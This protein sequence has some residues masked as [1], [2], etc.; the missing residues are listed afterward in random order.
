MGYIQKAFALAQEL[1]TDP[2]VI[3]RPMAETPEA[4]T[5]VFEKHIVPR[6]ALFAESIIGYGQVRRRICL[7][8]SLIVGSMEKST[9]PPLRSRDNSPLMLQ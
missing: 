7:I 4:V 8:F 2:F 6:D 5:P 1:R 9:L 3:K